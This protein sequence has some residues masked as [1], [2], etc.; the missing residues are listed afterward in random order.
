MGENY[1][2]LLKL[3]TLFGFLVFAFSVWEFFRGVYP[4]QQALIFLVQALLGIL[5]IYVPEFSKSC[6]VFNCPM[7]LFTFIGSFC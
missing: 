5:L 2:R 4:K 7:R 3:F 6:S 1:K